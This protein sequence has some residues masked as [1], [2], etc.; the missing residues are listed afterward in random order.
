MIAV[1]NLFNHAFNPD[2]L[3]EI[4]LISLSIAHAI[5]AESLRLLIPGIE[6]EH[7]RVSLVIDLHRAASICSSSP[8]HGRF[9][10][11]EWSDADDNSD[12]IESCPIC[13]VLCL[14]LL[15]VTAVV[16]I[17]ILP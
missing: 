3:V 2:L 12:F 15:I 17:S 6:F 13:I 8:I 9:T 11:D 10:L 16:A 7:N 4:P 1:D 14:V 5:E